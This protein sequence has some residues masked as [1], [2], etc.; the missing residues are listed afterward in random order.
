M[1]IYAC[2]YVEFKEKSSHLDL[3]LEENQ[4]I[5]LENRNSQQNQQLASCHSSDNNTPD[6]LNQL[7]PTSNAANLPLQV[8]TLIRP[9]LSTPPSPSSLPS[10]LGKESKHF[11]I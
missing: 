8:E 5:S 4:N 7:P 11:L 9:P 6:S 2:F 1:K 3:L 10:L